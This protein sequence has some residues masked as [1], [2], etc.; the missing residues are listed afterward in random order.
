MT[1]HD[2]GLAV[3]G[4]VGTQPDAAVPSWDTEKLMGLLTETCEFYSV[5]SCRLIVS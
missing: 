1:G 5:V 3:L 2:L 4:W